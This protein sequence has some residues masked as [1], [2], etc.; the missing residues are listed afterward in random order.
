[1]FFSLLVGFFGV[2]LDFNFLEAYISKI[3]LLGDKYLQ[4]SSSTWVLFDRKMAQIRR[5]LTILPLII[6]NRL[7][8]LLIH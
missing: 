6:V 8:A 5:F 1:M 3:Q 7:M 4:E 2:R